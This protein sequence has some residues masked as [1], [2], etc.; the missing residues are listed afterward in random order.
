MITGSFKN[1]HIATIT[2]A[3]H[4]DKR[5]F[6]MTIN[7]NQHVKKI[8]VHTDQLM[9]DHVYGLIL[10]IQNLEKEYATL[11]GI[12]GLNIVTCAMPIIQSLPTC[13][14]HLMF[15]IFLVDALLHKITHL[16]LPVMQQ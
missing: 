6:A 5:I 10:I 3:Y 4:V 2:N 9:V 7:H 13:N 16:V 14:V 15:A 12:R 11:K 1:N 8:I